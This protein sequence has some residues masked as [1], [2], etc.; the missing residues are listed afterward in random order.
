MIEQT[1]SDKEM[2][3]WLESQRTSYGDG[4]IFRMSTTGRGWRMHEAKKEGLEDI[5]VS[6]L[7]R[8]SVREAIADAMKRDR[9]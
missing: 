1:P 5:G 2:I 8:P 3:D 7:P 9:V 4:I 6:H